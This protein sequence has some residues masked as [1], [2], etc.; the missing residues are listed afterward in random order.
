MKRLLSILLLAIAYLLF[1]SHEL[2]LKTDSYFL[3]SGQASELYLFNGTFDV[4]ENK[5][6]RDRI[7]DARIMGPEYEQDVVDD[8]YYDKGNS[9]FLRFKA[10]QTG[11]YVAGISTI[12]KMIELDADAFNEYLD[13]EGLEDTIEERKQD[14]SYANGA[15]EKYSKHVKLVFQVGDKKTEDYNKFYGY[16]IEFVPLQNFYEMG[17][18]DSYS[19]KL[20]RSGKPLKNHIVHY[21]TSMPGKDAHEN[22]NST[23]TD[24]NGIMT[25]MPTQAGNWYVA[26]IHMEKSSEMGV[27]YESNWATLTFGVKD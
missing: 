23:R 6:T 15:K 25:M 9:T 20:L 12:P 13:H 24:E 19:F 18:G 5:I 11:T 22:E 14:G 7:Q 8:D 3:E 2:F 1:S 27:D 16:P 26:T 21:S 17:V 4:S 10:G